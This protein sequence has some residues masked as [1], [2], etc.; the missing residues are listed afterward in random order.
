MTEP[1]DI[2][3]TPPR[4][5]PCPTPNV[6]FGVSGPTVIWT[7]SGAE[8]DAIAKASRILQNTGLYKDS[9]IKTEVYD[10][11]GA[12]ARAST[13]SERIHPSSEQRTNTTVRASLRCCVHVIAGAG[14]EVVNSRVVF[15]L[16]EAP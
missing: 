4:Y 16:R 7:N 5:S 10:A 14:A 12:C 1:L 2:A 8:R 3:L 11:S 6:Q 15:T 9:P 13:P